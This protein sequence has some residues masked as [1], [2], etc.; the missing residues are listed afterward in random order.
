M[1][2]FKDL[3]GQRFGRLVVK[4]ML[5]ERKNH[6]II[7]HCVCDCG[8][9]IEIAGIQ[10]TK[11]TQ[12]TRSCGCLQKDRTRETSQ[13]PDLSGKV[14][15]R[16]TVIERMPN[17]SL[18]KCLC[19]CGTETLVT[20]N[21]LNSGHTQSCGCLQKDVTV[22]RCAINLSGQRFGMLTV[23]GLNTKLSQPKNRVYTCQCD[24]GNI[25]YVQGKNLSC[26]HT[27]SCGCTRLSHGEIKIKQILQEYNIPF[28][29]EK[30]FQTCISPKTKKQLR[31][32]FYVNNQYLIEYDGK[33]HFQ[34]EAGWDE[35]LSEIQYRDQI[36]NQWCEENNIPLIRIPY[37]KYDTLTIDDLLLP[38][39][40]DK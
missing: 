37:T 8:K 36:K 24:C 31:F 1:P 27:Q 9:E 13:G 3:T 14:F 28:E 26:G 19:Q 22:E 4:S 32:D 18:W 29:M 21:H 30:S 39:D 11:T 16:L 23:L 15:G 6:R 12:P 10:L 40:K 33:Q 17:S 2:A 35:E 5:P 38:I 7:W 34:E 25:C 20:T